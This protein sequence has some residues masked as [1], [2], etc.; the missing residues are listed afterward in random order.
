MAKPTAL[1]YQKIVRKLTKNK[2]E[3]SDQI[4]ELDRKIT[5]ASELA[6]EIKN[7]CRHEY[8]Y[9]ICKNPE[10]PEPVDELEL[11]A[12]FPEIHY[13]LKIDNK[14]LQFIYRSGKYEELVRFLT[15]YNIVLVCSKCG[16]KNLLGIGCEE[17]ANLVIKI[18]STK[19][20]KKGK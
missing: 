14:K 12:N 10:S 11:K 4:K 9:I 18:K 1:D 17:D 2:K 7:N 6:K 13:R 16:S 5:K 8:E 19:P 3:L 20:P 15:Y